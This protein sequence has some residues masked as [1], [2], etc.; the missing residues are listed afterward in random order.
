M[1]NRVSFKNSAG[2]KIAAKLCIPQ[3]S[4]GNAIVIL[5]CFL[6]TKEHHIVETLSERLC[7][8]G[9][10]V[11]C[12]DFSG[13]GES[14][15]EVEK[16]TYSK[17]LDEASSAV[18]FLR[19]Q[20][21]SKIGIA[22]HS[23]GAMISLLCASYDKRIDAV[24]FISG[25][26]QAARV[27]EVFPHD[28]VNKAEREGSAVARV[29]GR[30]IRLTR[31]FLDDIDHYNVGHSIATLGRPILIAHGKDDVIIE[32]HHARKLY[33][34]ASEPKEL[35]LIEGDHQFRNSMKQLAEEVDSFFEKSL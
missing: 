24:A 5:H 16:A 6:C 19:E 4:N 14:E 35:R 10:A 22:G 8:S 27:R 26:S 9:F 20:G 28:I 18:S 15:G 23:L 29:Y 21:Y 34:W 2:D 7:K 32:P 30:D 33:L 12:F 3:Q 31:E 1:D 17:M 13:N 11:L 25:S